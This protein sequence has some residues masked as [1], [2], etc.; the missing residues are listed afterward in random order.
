MRRDITENPLRGS[1][2]LLAN[3]AFKADGSAAFALFND[4]IQTV[5]SAAAD[6][7]D[8]FRIDA[9]EF[10]IGVLASALRGNIRDSA[11]Q[12]FEQGLLNALTGYIACNGTVF[13][14][15]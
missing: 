8:V 12:N 2:R 15:P 4:F 5:E 7:Q 9:D 13:T 1:L 3:F 11:F 10:L 14:L 6:K